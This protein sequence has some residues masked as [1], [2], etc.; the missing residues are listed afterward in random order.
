M[1]RT[2]LAGALALCLASAP[3]SGQGAAPDGPNL[4][5]ILAERPAQTLSA[6]RLF[7]DARADTPTAGVTPYD[8]ATPLFS[9]Y[10]LKSRYVFMPPGA[11]ATYADDDAFA[12]P[13]GTVLAK[14][15]AYPADFRRP[16]SDVRKIETRLLIRH[17]AGWT[18]Q[19]YVWDP[20]GGEAR[21]QIA[22]ARMPVHFVDATGAARDIQYAVPNKNQCKGCHALGDALTP[23]GPRARNLNR[24]FIYAAGAENQIA[25]WSRAGLLTGA[26]D[27][28]HAP[29]VPLFADPADGTLDA[30][31]RAYLDV[32]CAHCHNPEGPASNSGLDLRLTQTDPVRWGLRKRPVAAGRATADLLYAIDPGHPDRSIL[33]HRMESVDPGVMMPELGR[34]TVHSEGAALVRRWIAAMDD[35]GH[36]TAP[37]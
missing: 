30:R 10:A 32:N 2:A 31:A 35:N 22:G 16:A 7:R 3:V 37:H 28:A 23:L 5:A 24:S 19:T 4:T 9:D 20:D 1:R 8:L 25:H 15:F 11:V 18:A 17:A 27:P 36:T 13:V 29:R 34:T 12:F 26:P 21:L 6:Y 33:V 14:T